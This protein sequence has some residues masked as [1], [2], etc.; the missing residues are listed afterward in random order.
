MECAG[1]AVAQAVLECL[2]PGD[3]VVVVCG[4]GNNGGDGLVVARHLHLLRRTGCA[5]TRPRTCGGPE[6]LALRSRESAGAPRARECSWTRCW[7]RGSPAT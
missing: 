3:P 2:Q 1:R 6:P 4:A 7:A 5:A